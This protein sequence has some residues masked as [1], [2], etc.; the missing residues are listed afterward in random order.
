MQQRPLASAMSFMR[1]H[2]PSAL[3]HTGVMDKYVKQMEADAALLPLPV[4]D[5][6]NESL[7]MADL[8]AFDAHAR[9]SSKNGE[10]TVFVSGVEVGVPIHVGSIAQQEV[11]RLQML[12]PDSW[13]SGD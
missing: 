1:T 3:L 4:S 9:L 10:G 5:Y 8:S 7:H 13:S 11:S 12:G 2:M 6:Y